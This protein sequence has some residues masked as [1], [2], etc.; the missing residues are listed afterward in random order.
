M[1]AIINYGAGNILS[2]KN[3]V[4]DFTDDV[5]ITN[6]IDTLQKADKIILPGVGEASFAMNTLKTNNID[7]FLQSTKKPVLGICLGMQ[8]MCSF[9]EEGNVEC[10]NLF[11]YKVL[12]FDETKIK[13]PH[14]GWNS[15]K[16]T[17]ESKLLLNV[18]NNSYFYF[19]N[20]Y[21][22]PL[23]EHATG[24]TSYSFEFCSALEK[25]NFY[26]VQFHPE[27]SSSIGKQIIRNF[28]NL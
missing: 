11:P 28:I 6:D 19:A 10:L 16:F 17:R 1:I 12:K 27:K 2:V 8:L 15:V 5:I 4:L 24:I 20:S 25:D 14:M 26:G 13:V 23:N 22:I 9:S 3:S 21:Y 7:K 18:S